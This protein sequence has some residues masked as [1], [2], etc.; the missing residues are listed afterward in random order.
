MDLREAI[1]RGPEEYRNAMRSNLDGI[2]DLRNTE[3]VD[4]ATEWAPGKYNSLVM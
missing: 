3:D 1:M 4:K 2:V